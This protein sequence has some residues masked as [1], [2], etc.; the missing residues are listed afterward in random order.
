MQRQ[1][2]LS[3]LSR[4]GPHSTILVLSSLLIVSLAIALRLPSLYQ[5]INRDSSAYATIGTH[6]THGDFPYR[7]LF[8]HKQPLIYTVF[9]VLAVVA[10]RSN[11]AIQLAAAVISGIAGVTVF[12]LLGRSIGPKR[13]GLASVL[14]VSL[15][16]SR[17]VEGIDLNTE[18][19]LLPIACAAVLLPLSLGKQQ[20]TRVVALAGVLGGFAILAKAVAIMILPSTIFVLALNRGWRSR[21]FRLALSI[22]LAGVALPI[23]VLLVLYALNGGLSDL[24]Y[25]NITYNSQYIALVPFPSLKRLIDFGGYGIN[26]LLALASLIAVLRLLRT[27]GKDPLTWT[28]VI[29]LVGSMIGAK[30]GRRDFPHYFAP[31]LPPAISLACLPVPLDEPSLRRGLR[32]ITVA[33]LALVSMPFLLD[34]AETFGQNPDTL[35]TRLYGS[36]AI[37]WTKQEEVGAWLRGNATENDA[38][39]VSGAE[40]GF[41][42]QSGLKPATR[43][44]YDTLARIQADFGYRVSEELLKKPPRFIVLTG[45]KTPA[46]LTT[47]VPLYRM[48]AEFG[49]VRILELPRG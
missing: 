20:S 49:S 2:C 21:A 44:L 29:W 48:A 42:W 33:L 19:L 39:F 35:A 16:A 28:L 6:I 9:W 27:R 41:Y 23:L 38:L 17:F 25:A 45:P 47:L 3:Q 26:G 31:I 43:Y 37:T 7:D 18:H 10:P 30:L 46:Y 5:P 22:Y 34:V 24:I 4:T 13:A 11:L 15:G 12:I 40:P 8:D 14:I 1:A 36:Q 32:V